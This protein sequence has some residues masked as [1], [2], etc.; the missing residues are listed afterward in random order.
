MLPAT[1]WTWCRTK[2]RIRQPISSSATQEVP[3]SSYAVVVGSAIPKGMD[4]VVDIRTKLRWPPNEV[5]RIRL[6]VWLPVCQRCTSFLT[7]CAWHE[8]EDVEEVDS[9]CHLKQ[10]QARNSTTNCRTRRTYILEM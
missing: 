4:E 9:G 1:A 6:M 7:A 10:S 8:A 5:M 3:T 2:T